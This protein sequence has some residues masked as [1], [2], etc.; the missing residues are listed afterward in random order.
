[1]LVVA[2]VGVL[3]MHLQVQEDQHILWEVVEE[4]EEE[5]LEHQ[6]LMQLVVVEEVLP[7]EVLVPECQELVVPVVQ[8]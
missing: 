7:E 2:A 1:M 3:G 4:Q 6:E 5:L 8:E